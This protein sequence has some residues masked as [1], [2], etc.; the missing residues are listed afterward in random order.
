MKFNIGFFLLKKVLKYKKLSFLE[1]S[2]RP[3]KKKVSLNEKNWVPT[4]KKGRDL[5]DFQNQK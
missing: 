4:H 2:I 1:C 5:F 3:I